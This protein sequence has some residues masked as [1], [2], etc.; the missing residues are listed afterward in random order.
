MHDE[1]IKLR[2][3]QDPS[4]C[5]LNSHWFVE[6]CK[7]E[8]RMALSTHDALFKFVLQF[9][10]LRV[11]ASKE[12]SGRLTSTFNSKSRVE[13][14]LVWKSLS[15]M[16]TVSRTHSMMNLCVSIPSA[17]T[18]KEGTLLPENILIYCAV[19]RSIGIKLLIV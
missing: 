8:S 7:W 18:L 12:S 1:Q 3:A 14:L 19:P 2:C 9:I 13:S 16:A 6:N 5:E 4:V 17:R 10:E 15:I 11:Y